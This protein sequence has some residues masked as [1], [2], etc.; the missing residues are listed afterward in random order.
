[1][2]RL[3]A[4]PLTWTRAIIFGL[5]ITAALLVTLGWIP[6]H[7][8]YFIWPRLDP[9]KL[10]HSITGYKLK[11]TYTVVRIGDMISMGYQTVAFIIPLVITYVLMERR[12]RRMGQQ[13]AEEP[14]GYLP[15]K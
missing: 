9:E 14:K 12:R 15:G 10:I 6:S 8:D 4:A 7:F 13:G 2:K 11:E 3:F 5:V 1:M